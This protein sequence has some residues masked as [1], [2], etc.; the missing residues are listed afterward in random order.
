MAKLYFNFTKN[1][2]PTNEGQKVYQGC[3]SGAV[4]LSILGVG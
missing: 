4:A 1:L 3:A 2:F